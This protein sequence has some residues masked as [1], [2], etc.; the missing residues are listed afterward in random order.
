MP[1]AE[2]AISLADAHAP[3]ADVLF[4]LKSRLL[5]LR[6]GAVNALARGRPLRRVALPA[7]ATLLADDEHPLYTLTNPRERALELGKVQNLRI[8]AAAVDGTVVAPGETFSFWRAAGRATRAKGYVVG[9]EL[10]QGCMIPAVGGGVCQLTN[11]LSRV[12]HRAGMEIV[13]RHSH[14]VQPEGFFID[15]TTDATVFWNYIDFRFRSPRSVRIGATL[16]ETTLV[17]RLDALP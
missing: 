5:M 7:N 1:G 9:R 3:G 10:R 8:A 4:W 15:P 16:T 13:E 6:R 14:S 17:V 12:A 11:A 2:T